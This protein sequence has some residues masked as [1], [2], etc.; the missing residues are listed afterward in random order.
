MPD[1]Y[2]YEPMICIVL[3]GAKQLLVGDKIMRYDRATCFA[4][5]VNVPVTSCV[6]E[7]EADKP[8]V[9]VSLR[10]DQEILK[11]VLADAGPMPASDA[12]QGYGVAPVTPELLEAL[13]RLLMLLDTPE[14]IAFLAE[15]REREILYRVL[16]S[17][18][19]PMLRQMVREDSH[20]SQVR[21][22]VDW[23]RQNFDQR[24]RTE[25][26]AD[27]AGM[28]VPSFHRH[29]KAATAMSP[30][31]YQ[32]T[33]RLEA[34]RRMLATNADAGRAAYAVGY[35]SASQFSREY[36]R[37]FGVPPGRDAVR[38]RD[39]VAESSAAA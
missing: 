37:Q 23:I 14:D 32:K 22:T 5:S 19:G 4:A 2:I 8:Y 31:Q 20:L 10:I 29:F 27:L 7:A 34:A 15:A 33:I 35:E 36:A 17:G 11:Q 21:R 13:D 9:V 6:I 18:L 30:L 1:V 24:L 16:R 39:G 28:S 25:T 12:L 38:L 3:Q 26:L